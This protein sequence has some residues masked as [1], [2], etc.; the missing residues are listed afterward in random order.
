MCKERFHIL[1]NII[2][3]LKPF[4]IKPL[5]LQAIQRK[6]GTYKHVGENFID[7]ILVKL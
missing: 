5:L 6:Q 4:F 7:T 3:R 2:N 1:P